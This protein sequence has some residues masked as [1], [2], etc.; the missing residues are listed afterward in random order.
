MNYYKRHLGDYAKKAGRLS[1]LQHGAFNLLIDSCYDREQFPTMEEA[2]DWVWA[3]NS[4]EEDA[5]KFVLKK[6]FVLKN[7]VYIQNRIK[8]ELDIYHEKAEINKRIAWEREEKKKAAKSNREPISYEAFIKQQRSVNEPLENMQEW[9]PNHKPVTSNHKP[10][11][12]NQEP[13]INIKKPSSSVTKENSDKPKKYKFTDN[14]KKVANYIHNKVLVINPSMKTPNIEC[15]SNTIRLMRESDKRSY[16]DIYQVFSWANHDDFWHTNILSPSKLRKQFDV[17]N[18][19]MKSIMN[20]NLTKP[21]WSILPKENDESLKTFALKHG[22]QKPL[23]GNSWYEYRGRLQKE[24][25]QRL[26]TQ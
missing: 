10:V 17:L 21:P 16:D 8:E 20:G 3:S 4:E 24:I 12:N 23:P 25:N 5:V 15:W 26:N 22:L 2:L 18:V 7:G 6:F 13:N 19:K 1:M 9:Q 14:D 11:T